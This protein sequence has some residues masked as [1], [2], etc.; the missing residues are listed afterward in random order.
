MRCASLLLGP[1]LLLTWMPLSGCSPVTVS[2]TFGADPDRLEESVV[3]SEGAGRDKVALIDVRGIIADAPRSGLLSSSASP[4]DQ[5]TARLEKAKEDPRV[6]AVVLRLNSPGGTVAGSDVAYEEVRRF[7][8]ESEKPVVASMGEMATSGAYYLA[9]AADEIVAQPSTVTGSIGVIFPTVNVSEGLS[10]IGVK[11]RAVTS[12]P[13][14]DLANPLEPV[15]ETHYQ[16]LQ[17]IVDAF[18]DDF[19]SL[20][21]ERRE[22]LPEAHVD[23]ATDGRVVTGTRAHEL[24]LID[25]LGGLRD[26]IDRAKELASIDEARVVKYVTNGRGAR[27]PYARADLSEPQAETSVNLLNIQMPD[28]AAFGVLPP[29]A[30]YLWRPGVPPAR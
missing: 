4:V 26:A 14:K 13:N 7:I 20:V 24:G 22:Q 21:V 3:A 16:I 5:L 19:R 28:G 29:G 25:R 8:E 12:G 6:K 11:S 15:D 23:E 2:F 27:T 10:R 9:L 1:L 18:Y 17:G 30:Y